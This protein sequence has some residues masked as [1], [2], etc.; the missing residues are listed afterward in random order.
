M[1]QT[2]VSDIRR[3]FF[4]GVGGI[5]MSALARYFNARGVFVAGYDKTKTRLTEKL[6]S[7]G[8]EV[9]YEDRVD[10]IPED[11]DLV[12]YTPAIPSDHR[13]LTHLFASDIEVVKRAELLGIISRENPVIAVAGT[14]GKTS[15]S[16]LI[17]HILKSCNEDVSAF[18]GGI[19]SG[20]N[21]NYFLGSSPWVVVEA[22]EYDRSFLH[23]RPQISVLNSMDAD[24]LDIYGQEDQIKEGFIEFLHKTNQGGV[25][26]IHQPLQ[27]KIGQEEWSRLQDRYEVI[28]FG[29]SGAD[30]EV[31][32]FEFEDGMMTFDLEEDG[33]PTIGCKSHLI[34]RHN[35]LNASVAIKIARILDK[36]DDLIRAGLEQFA[37]IRRRFEV[38]YKSSDI[39][40]IDDYAHHPTELN[41]AIQAARDLYPERKILG[42]FQPHLYSRTRDF[43]EGFADALDKL[44]EVI[45]MDIYPARELPIE[46]VSSA[47]IHD[48]MKNKNA[49][50]VR[51]DEVITEVMKSDAQVILT[52]G[53]G[54][55]DLQV[56]IIKQYLEK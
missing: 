17:T 20:Y 4:V 37:G 5:G 22:D 55:I 50:R 39:I 15:T 44:D 33:H 14:H 12:V 19:I 36:E 16:A 27:E 52:L 40:Y 51:D 30:V 31:S 38:V 46:G 35:A 18:L 53:A 45:L 34:G 6:V 47:T 49:R 10:Y 24:H 32:N 25:L 8:I 1:T 7:E 21:T 13:Q 3:I 28:T 2:K 23:L 43:A 41:V 9:M 29:I 26:L 56:D 11:L 54:D 42:V 48:E